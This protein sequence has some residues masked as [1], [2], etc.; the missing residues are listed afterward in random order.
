M[1][2]IQAGAKPIL[3]DCHL[4]TAQLTLACRTKKL[5]PTPAPFS[6]YTCTDRWYHPNN[7]RILP[8][9]YNLIIFEDAAQAQFSQ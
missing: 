2:V 6:Q 4:D 7:Y 5:P 1:G 9:G 8:E 3:V